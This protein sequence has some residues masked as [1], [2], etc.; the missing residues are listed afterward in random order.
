[1]LLVE[2]GVLDVARNIPQ[3]PGEAGEQFV[4]VVGDH[5][6]TG[7]MELRQVRYGPQHLAALLDLLDQAPHVLVEV[8][9]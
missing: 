1:M 9:V 3:T 7:D 8:L 5:R 4:E 6:D 2:R